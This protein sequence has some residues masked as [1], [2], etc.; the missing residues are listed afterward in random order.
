MQTQ[1]EA[2]FRKLSGMDLRGFADERSR[3]KR[4]KEA[5]GAEDPTGFV[6][7]KVVFSRRSP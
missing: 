6:G 3:R 5:D 1:A 7:D 4:E 2:R